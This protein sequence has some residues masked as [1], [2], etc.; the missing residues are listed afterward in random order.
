MFA[1]QIDQHL[2][3]GGLVQIAQAELE[4]EAVQLR[5][6]QGKGTFVFDGVLGGNDEKRP[7]QPPRHAI[8]RNLAV[9]PSLP[10]APIGCAAWRG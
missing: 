7:F 8:H 5:F 10:A 6:G 1:A 2:A 9:R 3:F 4:E